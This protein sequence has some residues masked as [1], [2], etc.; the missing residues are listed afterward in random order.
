MIP[1][2]VLV[3]AIVGAGTLTALL[4]A[5]RRQRRRARREA[6]ASQPFPPA[7]R[8]LLETQ[9]E[10]YRWLPPDLREQLHGRIQIF[11]AEK[12][13]FGARGQ[14]VTDEVRLSI[15]AQ[16][17]LLLLNRETDF[18]PGLLSVVVYPTAFVTREPAVDTP[19]VHIDEDTV[20]GGESWPFGT[21]VLA[22]DEVAEPDP[23][24][25]YGLNLVLHE[26]AHQLDDEDG[27]SNGVP[28]LPS[29]AARKVWIRTL[30][31]EFKALQHKVKRQQV[32]V[33]D[34]YAAE[35]PAEFFAVAVETFFSLPE[36]LREEHPGLYTQLKTY[37]NLD[38]AAWPTPPEPS[39]EV[40]VE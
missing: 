14:A 24:G 27:D 26:F 16:A 11:L 37:F 40:G 13:F 8:H 20:M 4:L 7:W 22:W 29:R 30:A 33:L 36:N 19:D 12:Q 9:V 32:D 35:N 6:L 38:P 5:A 17:C 10:L 25:E 31:T 15:A 23:E 2:L 21:L 18:F 39:P 28:L 1:V 3:L 34:E